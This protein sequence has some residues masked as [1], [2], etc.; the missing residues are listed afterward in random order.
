[1]TFGEEFFE[2]LGCFRDG[3]GGGDADDV[4]ALPPRVGDQRLFQK[5]RSA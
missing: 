1:M 2:A 5:S 3:I 4:K